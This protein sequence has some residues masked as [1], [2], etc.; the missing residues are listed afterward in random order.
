MTRICGCFWG[1]WVKSSDVDGNL[2]PEHIRNP[3]VA[4]ERRDLSA[5]GVLLF[6]LA[7]AVTGLFMHLIIWAMFRNLSHREVVPQPSSQAIATPQ[8]TLPTGDPARSFPAPQLQPDPPAD[9]NKFVARENQILGSYDYVDKDR[10]VVRIPIDRAMQLLLQRGLPT[11]PPAAAAP[12]RTGPAQQPGKG[13]AN[14]A[15]AAPGTTR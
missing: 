14:R 5:R 8:N 13:G 7:L 9:L 11:R 3:E 10:G 6:L 4:Y 15:A 1:K 2:H 12:A